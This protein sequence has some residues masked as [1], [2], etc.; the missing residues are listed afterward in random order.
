MRFFGPEKPLFDKTWKLPD[1]EKA[2]WSQG[3]RAPGRLPQRANGAAALARRVLGA[4]ARDAHQNT[5]QVLPRYP[6]LQCERPLLGM[7]LLRVTGR[8]C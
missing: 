2:N 7:D 1:V 6:W 3:K 4:Q 5:W 8:S